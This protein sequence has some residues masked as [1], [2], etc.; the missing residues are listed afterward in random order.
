MESFVLYLSQDNYE[1]F[2]QMKPDLPRMVSFKS[3]AVTSPLV[4]AIS[5]QFLGKL[6]VAEVDVHLED[7]FA[8]KFSIY[9]TDEKPPTLIIL[10]EPNNY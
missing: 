4:K 3:R 7:E 5:K 9:P 6:I 2:C 8:Q 10:T 1:E